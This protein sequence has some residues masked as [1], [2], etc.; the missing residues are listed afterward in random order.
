MKKEYFKKRVYRGDYEKDFYGLKKDPDGVLRD[1]TKEKKENIEFYKD[2]IK[3]INKLKTNK[4]PRFLDLGCGCGFVLSAISSKYSKYGLEVSQIGYDMTKK[5]TFNVYHG[6]LKR[7]T[8]PSNFFDVVFCGHVIEHVKDPLTFVRII[9]KIL[10]KNGNLII[11]TPNF[12]SG[13]ARRFKK[14]Y[15]LL[16]HPSHISLFSDIGLMKMLEDNGFIVDRIEY[17]FFNTKYFTKENLLRLFD[18]SK[19][20]PPFYGNIMS[21][22]CRKK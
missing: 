6:E 13:G 3:F 4:K 2:E 21:L 5:V 20:S 10:K 1:V 12:D 8:Y 19:V 15:R 9:N 18:T 11:A 7:N 16:K 17:P 14:N 22:Y